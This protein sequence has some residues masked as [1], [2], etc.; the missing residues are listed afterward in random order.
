ML[1]ECGSLGNLLK[2][3]GDEVPSE[4]S[5]DSEVPKQ[6]ALPQ[7]RSPSAIERSFESAWAAVQRAPGATLVLLDALEHLRT[8]RP[9]PRLSGA[10]LEKPGAPEAPS[11]QRQNS[12]SICGGKS[13]VEMEVHGFIGIITMCNESKRN[14]LSQK[15]GMVSSWFLLPLKPRHVCDE[16]SALL[17][18]CCSAGV[19][20]VILRSSPGVKVWSSGHDVR[21]FK[22]VDG[23]DA[24]SFGK[25]KFQDP[26]SCED[27]FVKLL[28]RIRNLPV[29]VLGSIEGTVWGGATD[30]CACCD[31][32]IATPQTSFAITPAKIGL[33][34]NHSGMSHF[35]Q[36]MP[37]HIVKWMFFSGEPISADQALQIGFLN[38]VVPVEKLEQRTVFE[39]LH[40]K[41][42]PPWGLNFVQADPLRQLEDM[43]KETQVLLRRL[44]PDFLVRHLR[45][46][47]ED[48]GPVE[49]SDDELAAELKRLAPVNEGLQRMA[50]QMGAGVAKRLKH[51][52]RALEGRA[53][54][55][56]DV[57]KT[58]TTAAEAF[59]QYGSSPSSSGSSETAA[60]DALVI[61]TDEPRTLG[62]GTAAR[63]C[64]AKITLGVA[65]AAPGRSRTPRRDTRP[66]LPRAPTPPP[67]PSPPRSAGR[68]RPLELRRR[69]QPE[70][71]EEESEEEEVRQHDGYSGE[72]ERRDEPRRE[73]KEEERGRAMAE[74][75]LW[76]GTDLEEER[77]AVREALDRQPKPNTPQDYNLLEVDFWR[78]RH[79]PPGSVLVYEPP[80]ETLGPAGM[81]AVLVLSSESSDKGIWLE[82]KA[83]GC[84]EPGFRN[85]L[86]GLYKAHRKHHHLCYVDDEGLC[87]AIEDA[88]IHLVNFRWYPPGDFNEEWISR[89]SQRLVQEGV[90]MAANVTFAGDLEP[91]SSSYPEGGPGATRRVGALRKPGDRSLEE[92]LVETPT[93][94]KQEVV[95]VPDS[96]SEPLKKERKKKKKPKGVAETLAQAVAARQ[97]RQEEQRQRKRRSRSGSSHRDRKRRRRRRRSSSQES[98]AEESGS[99]SSSQSLQPPLKKRSLKD[100]GSVFRLLVTQAAEQLAQEGLEGEEVSG[101]RSSGQRVKMYT[102]YQLALKPSLDPRSRDAKELALLAKA[103]DLMQEGDLPQLADL[104]AARLIA[105][106][107]A[108]RQGWQAAKYLEIQSLEDDGTAPP[109]ILLAA[110]KHQKQVEKA[111]GKGSWT[112]SQTWSGEW[113]GDG[114]PKGKNKGQKGKGK[115]GK[116]KAQG[117]KGAW[118]SWNTADKEK[119]TE[120]PAKGD[121]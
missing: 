113:Q 8:A 94:V 33:P 91:P 7:A 79:I 66:P 81:I 118:G 56:E 1:I 98:S 70:P 88:G 18:R 3:V 27:S 65:R 82:V 89:A 51:A 69:E 103:L 12:G 29:P 87:P 107:T 2:E 68:E 111:G 50:Q 112:R 48:A 47:D 73:V 39:E 38:D 35:I 41:R 5:D 34:Y 78:H 84:K 77:E 95:K 19:R 20:V 99:S 31:V 11:I 53:Q 83:L 96:D 116:G 71:D 32:L 46:C 61:I 36:V 101:A 59:G 76:R 15:L 37:L 102:Y 108:T 105:V 22:R 115:K 49:L 16:L 58:A 64:I 93:T 60:V 26:L 121:T 67:P 120:K 40:E 21:D 75:D 110:M 45:E 42:H 57:A 80:E 44:P 109:H 6:E 117:G 114:R 86:A 100:P 14:A 90:Q 25:S 62:G 43:E 106:D 72:E 119:T 63:K 4:Q 24:R 28:D 55:L 97:T 30:I 13:A 104:L 10:W 17:E 54:W 9:W 74:S 52:T 92:A 85:R 23:S